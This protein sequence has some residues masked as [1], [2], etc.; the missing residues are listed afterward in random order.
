MIT[1]K[2]KKGFF[3]TEI[4]LLS[5]NK[6]KNSVYPIS[7]YKVNIAKLISTENN[8]GKIIESIKNNPVMDLSKTLF[9]YSLIIS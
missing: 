2:M 7:A 5:L 6:F 8:R 1:A 9:I 4:S 3:D